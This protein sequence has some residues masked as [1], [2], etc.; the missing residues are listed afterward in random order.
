[1]T[2]GVAVLRP[3]DLHRHRRAPAR[4]E[5]QGRQEGAAR[6]RH[7]VRGHR[8]P[9]GGLDLLERPAA[10]GPRLRAL[11]RSARCHPE[12]RALSQ[13]R[14]HG[15]RGDRQLDVLG[16]ADP[17][18]R[19]SFRRRRSDRADRRASGAGIRGWRHPARDPQGDRRRSPRGAPRSAEPRHRPLGGSPARFSLCP[20]QRPLRPRG[21]G[22]SSPSASTTWTPAIPTRR[23]PTRSSAYP[24][25]SA[26]AD[27][28]SP[29][30][31]A[32]SSARS[33]EFF[34]EVGP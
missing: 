15:D 6:R 12:R 28:C 34:P 18:L 32:V 20:P 3:G 25:P 17:H 9:A 24:S 23:G 27:P 16:G 21:V 26:P 22:V 29:G 4:S 30:S 11:G 1:M 2:I 14:A 5:K 31:A 7:Y 19:P 10:D 13:G 8:R 33:V